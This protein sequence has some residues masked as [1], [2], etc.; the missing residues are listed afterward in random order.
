[1]D[2]TS[3]CA[4]CAPLG[5][6]AGRDW[7]L[8]SGV[9]SDLDFSA[10][11]VDGSEV[12]FTVSETVLLLTVRS[13]FALSGSLFSAVVDLRLDSSFGAKSAGGVS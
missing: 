4:R 1:L 11:G 6:G 5:F 3:F 10:E 7:E 9:D 8:N 13:F 2:G 12:D